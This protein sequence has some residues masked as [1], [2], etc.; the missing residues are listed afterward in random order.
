MNA[1]QATAL[2]KLIDA[3]TEAFAAVCTGLGVEDPEA[4]AAGI[5]KELSE[6]AAEEVSHEEG[7]D[8]AV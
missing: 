1:E 8:E 6:V 7:G 3:D 5:V 2:L 4:F